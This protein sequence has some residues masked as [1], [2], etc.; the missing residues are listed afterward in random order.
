M[1]NDKILI[2][3]G[4]GFIGKHLTEYLQQFD[5]DI[6]SL[7]IDKDINDKNNIFCDLKDKNK[8]DA[9]FT[10]NKFDY[11][12]HLAAF[13]D[14]SSQITDFYSSI[15]NNLIGS[16]N[17]FSSAI[18]NLKLKKI[19]ILGT[20]E[21]YGNNDIPFNEKQRES[22]VSSYSFSKVCVSHLCDVFYKLY[23]FPFVILRPSIA[24]G[25]GQQTDMFL[26]SLINSLSKNLE[27]EMTAGEQ[28]RDFVYVK[29]L[30][31]AIYSS[32]INDSAIGRIINVG[33][34]K[35]LTIKEISL[36][37]GEIMDRK[38]LIKFG[39]KDYR[40]NEIMNYSLDISLAKKLLNWEPKVNLEEGL[41]ETINYYLRESL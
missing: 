36:K 4:S 24:Y 2:T 22:P 9:I 31:E 27:F 16:V 10:E 20:A 5:F 1:N 26:P 38:N 34:G 14:R 21:E 37:V 19:V 32:L 41:K 7:S 28:T 40:N 25:P 17:L 18:Q 15:E 35:P 11:I 8:I 3:G 23:N 39:R 6:Y 13:K 30:V 33:D 29:D 12:I